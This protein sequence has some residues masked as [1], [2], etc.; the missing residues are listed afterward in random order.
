M[1]LQPFTRDEIRLIFQLS[2]GPE[3]GGGHAGAQ[4]VNMSKERLWQR[5]QAYKGPGLALRTSFLTFADQIEAAFQVLNDPRND[6]ALEDFRVNA[7]AGDRNHFD[8]L[9]N[10]PL[11]TPIRTHYGIGGGAQVFPCSLVTLI[12]HKNLSRPRGMHVVTFFGTMGPMV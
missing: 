6:A 12:L 4:H 8:R 11:A 10:L 1:P 2:E 5:V 3:N 9:K 7:K